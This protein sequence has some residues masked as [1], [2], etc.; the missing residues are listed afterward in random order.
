MKKRKANQPE[1][2]GRKKSSKKLSQIFTSLLKPKGRKKTFAGNCKL[3]WCAYRKNGSKRR[4]NE[5]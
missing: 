2:K 3:H 1:P 5:I 4:D